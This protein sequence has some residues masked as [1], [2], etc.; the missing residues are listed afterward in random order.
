MNKEDIR[1]IFKA[2]NKDKVVNELY[3]LYKRFKKAEGIV[4]ADLNIESGSIS[5]GFLEVNGYEFEK[6]INIRICSKETGTNR[7]DSKD[8]LPLFID[9]KTFEEILNNTYDNLNNL[10]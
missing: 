4:F 9:E 10:K 1:K 2:L 5:F 7:N 6:D 3:V 8:A